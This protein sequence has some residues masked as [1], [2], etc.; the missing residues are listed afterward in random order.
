MWALEWLLDSLASSAERLSSF[1][2]G[3][4]EEKENTTGVW[5]SSLHQQIND[6]NSAHP[7]LEG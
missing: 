1:L 3:V 5:A 7:T 4:M 2:Q 6:I